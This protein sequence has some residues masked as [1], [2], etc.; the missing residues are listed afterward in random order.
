MKPYDEGEIDR[1]ID[2]VAGI[3]AGNSG[4]PAGAA[5]SI[6]DDPLGDAPAAEEFGPPDPAAQTDEPMGPP[7]PLAGRV[8][9]Y[10]SQ[11]TDK[12]EADV[13]EFVRGLTPES[14]KPERYSLADLGFDKLTREDLAEINLEAQRRPEWNDSIRWTPEDWP[15]RGTAVKLADLYS[16]TQ[17]Q[18]AHQIGESTREQQRHILM[19]HAKAAQDETFGSGVARMLKG[20]VTTGGEFAVG[21]GASSLAVKAGAKAGLN[22]ATKAALGEL[23]KRASSRATQSMVRLVD[24]AAP[25]AAKAAPVLRRAAGTSLAQQAIPFAFGDHA[26]GAWD[27][28]AAQRAFPDLNLSDEEAEHLATLLDEDVPAFLNSLTS[29]WGGFA[30]SMIVNSVEQTGAHLARVPPFRYLQAIQTKALQ[31]LGG[32]GS[33]DEIIQRITAALGKAGDAV[34]YDGPLEEVLEEIASGMAVEGLLGENAIDGL[35]EDVEELAQLFV[36]ASVPAGGRAGL[37]RAGQL[38][39]IGLGSLKKARDA[40]RAALP[41]RQAERAE[42]EAIA[43]AGAA[44]ERDGEFDPNAFRLVDERHGGRP[45]AIASGDAAGQ[46]G[47]VVSI[48]RYNDVPEVGQKAGVFAQV[49]LADG[50]IVTVP[51]ADLAETTVAQGTAPGAEDALADQEAVAA[52]EQR[53]REALEGYGDPFSDFGLPLVPSRIAAETSLAERL[54][55]RSTSQRKSKPL[56]LLDHVL[57]LGGFNTAPTEGRATARNEAG[58]VEERL[59]EFVQGARGYRD[60]IQRG[61][62]GGLRPDEMLGAL[63]ERGFRV[64]DEAGGGRLALDEVLGYLESEL[65]G[66]EPKLSADVELE[67]IE[68]ESRRAADVDGIHL[69]LQSETDPAREQELEADP[70]DPV[71]GEGGDPSFLDDDSQPEVGQDAPDLPGGLSEAD[72]PFRPAA[73]PEAEIDLAPLPYGLPAPLGR[74]QAAQ[75]PQDGSEGPEAVMGRPGA[76][77]GRRGARSAAEAAQQ[78]LEEAGAPEGSQAATGASSVTGEGVAAED[79][80]RLGKGGLGMKVPNRSGASALPREGRAP[81]QTGELVVPD[82]GV[83]TR[84]ESPEAVPA[85]KYGAKPALIDQGE[86]FR[87]IG[88]DLFGSLQPFDGTFKPGRGVSAP[89]VMKSYLEAARVLG[90]NP[91]FRGTSNPK[92]ALGAFRPQSGT[93]DLRHTNDL[94]TAAHEIAHAIETHVFGFRNPWVSNGAAQV[95]STHRAELVQLGKELYGKQKPAGGYMREGWAEFLRMWLTEGGTR[96]APAMTAWMDGVFL[97]S[98]PKLAKAL[99]NAQAMTREWRLQGSKE[100][101]RQHITFKP[102]GRIGQAAR[103]VRDGAATA[104]FEDQFIDTFGPLRRFTKEAEKQAGRTLRPAQNPF[105]LGKA[106]RGAV[107]ARLDFWVRTG[108]TDLAGQP[109]GKPGLMA[110]RSMVKGRYEDFVIYLTARRSK[111]LWEQPLIERGLL[112]E[113]ESPRAAIER[114][115]AGIRKR[116]G[117]K[118]KDAPSPELVL[119]GMGARDSG[120]SYDD[121]LTILDELESPDFQ[122][123]AEGVYQWNQA[124]LDYIADASPT[125][126]ASVDVINR[127]DAG[128]YIPLMR[129]M[130]KVTDA[131]GKQRVAAIS[132]GSGN[133]SKKLKG[134]G[135]P[136]RDPFQQML[137]NASQRM[138]MAHKRAVIEAVLQAG[139]SIPNLGAYIRERSPDQVPAAARKVGDLIRQIAEKAEGAGVDPEAIEQLEDAFAE[140]GEFS[141]VAAEL[142][143]FFEET[144]FPIKEDP[145]WKTLPIIDQGRLRYFDISADIYDAL[146]GLEIPVVRGILKTPLAAMKR[147]AVLGTTGMSPEF[148]LIANTLR[149]LPTFLVQSRS[150]NPFLKFSYWAWGLG[151]MAVGKATGG[152]IASEFYD[153]YKR[154]GVQ[155]SQRYSEDRGFTRRTARRLAGRGYK[156][157]DVSSPGAFGKSLA[158]RAKELPGLAFDAAYE[159][160]NVPEGAAR[161]AEMR[162]AAKEAGWEPGDSLTMDQFVEVTLAGR[163]V[164]VDFGAAGKTTGAYNQVVPFFNVA[165]QGPRALARALKERPAH[166][167]FALIAYA[168]LPALALWRLNKDEEWYQEMP[169]EERYSHFY[170]R[171]PGTDTIL[172]FPRAFEIHLGAATYPEIL[173]NKMAETDPEGADSLAGKIAEAAVVATSETFRTMT[174]PV[175]PVPVSIAVEQVANRDFFWGSPIVSRGLERYPRDQRYNEYTPRVAIAAGKLLGVEPTRI[176]HAI[177][178]LTGSVGNTLMRLTGRDIDAVK[179]EKEASDKFIVGRLFRRGGV[180]NNRSRSIDELYDRLQSFEERRNDRTRTEPESEA[181]EDQ[182]IALQNATGAIQALSKLRQMTSDANERKELAS[183]RVRIAR[184]ALKR[185]EGPDVAEMRDEFLDAKNEYRAQLDERREALGF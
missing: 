120:I 144:R 183:L 130:Q 19:T 31:R 128:D 56:T 37:Q 162:I 48:D 91:T 66:A 67:L 27:L 62:Q 50:S 178:G 180:E 113:G 132:A 3:I 7:G 69:D 161:L 54:G 156:V 122:L 39:P 108:P 129:D 136:V 22:I 47:I 171:V 12:L 172:R 125:Y 142:L 35:P 75:E 151:E 64:Q 55:A 148:A 57:E 101:A 179:R 138:E 96:K 81:G 8:A 53:E 131:Y 135:L 16:F 140:G 94:A 154:Q 5:T 52:A 182:R 59:G 106:L 139:Q 116:E 89:D 77:Q 46:V 61:E 98:N 20:F 38:K 76:G 157:V 146:V 70:F 60:L 87:P 97:P 30:E 181:E 21:A 72:V 9:E 99:K 117:E 121:T 150:G 83:P 137:T 170:V 63:A 92:G 145:G 177:G 110:L 10:R 160:L 85:R 43:D 15:F 84:P 41:S 115:M 167:G 6:V 58:D 51:E 103:A 34:A 112:R 68:R 1:R 65:A 23:R 119:Q 25:A 102:P 42:M 158:E 175:L 79:R 44:A 165:F 184:D 118:L 40:A 24:R 149:D 174:P 159:I 100:R 4:A 78:A 73:D 155:M 18:A 32:T 28:Y 127:R 143:V 169:D 105:K 141:D 124:L 176:E 80:A 107:A 36:A 17:A 168:T 153:L 134:S 152:R 13:D 74:S 11:H 88:R 173:L 133:V 147:V 71:I 49:Q 114:I 33:R 26:G 104:A 126:A 111:R 109:T 185:I 123:A 29:R 163:E 95:S 45:I 14:L 90:A 93:I 86:V 166:T 2:E 82:S 164:T